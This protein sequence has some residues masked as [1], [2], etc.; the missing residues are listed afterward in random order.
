MITNEI[1]NLQFAKISKNLL[2]KGEISK[3]NLSRQK[4]KRQKTKHASL[5]F[6]H[7]YRH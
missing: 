3:I 1:S 4:K 6:V 7:V 2:G 5:L